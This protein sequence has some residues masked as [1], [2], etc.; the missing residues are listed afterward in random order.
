V[1]ENNVVRKEKLVGRKV[2]QKKEN[3]R[4]VTGW[5]TCSE[6][7]IQVKSCTQRRLYVIK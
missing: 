4:E 5:T 6:L 3:R 2:Q 1:D 7:G